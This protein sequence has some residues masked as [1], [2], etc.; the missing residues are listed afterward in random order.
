LEK[1]YIPV[2]VIVDGIRFENLKQAAASLA[3]RVSYWKLYRAVRARHDFVA[4]H[5]VKPAPG[6]RLIVS[7]VSPDEAELIPAPLREEAP[8]G[9]EPCGQLLRYPRA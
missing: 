7:V 2:P 8:R 3:P 4:G 9:R 6:R 5:R 1:G